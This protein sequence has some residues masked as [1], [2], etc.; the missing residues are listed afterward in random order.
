MDVNFKSNLCFQ[1]AFFIYKPL[2]L[3]FESAKK[4]KNYFKNN[5]MRL[6]KNAE[7]YAD[8]KKVEKFQNSYKKTEGNFPFFLFYTWP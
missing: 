8:V 6:S 2:A 3:K 7:F 1:K 4:R 5:F